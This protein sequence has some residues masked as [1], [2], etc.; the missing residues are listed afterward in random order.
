MSANFH[1]QHLSPDLMLDALA[2]VHIYPESGLL[3][4][5]SY[6]NRVVQFK[7]D[8][9][10]RYVA[11]FYRP[12]RWNQ[13]QLEEEH[14]F[15]R[16][17]QQEELPIA[18]PIAFDGQS[19]LAFAGF[20]YCV[21]PSTGGRAI[22]AENWDQLE[23]LGSLLGQIHQVGLR[24]PFSARP[25]L[26]LTE[27]IQAGLRQLSQSPQVPARWQI[28]WMDFAS[29]CQRQLASLS[30]KFRRV[31]GDCHLGNVL[32]N[33]GL[34]L[35]DFDDCLQAPAVQD[36]W[37]LLHGDRAEQQLQLA[38]LLDGY[39][40]F[41]DFSQSELAWIEPLRLRRM[42]QQMAWIDKRWQDPLFVSS[43]PW[44][45]QEDY[46]QGQWRSLQQ[47]LADCQ[48]PPFSVYPAY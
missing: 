43:F 11:K 18:Y 35:L 21:Y 2:A 15:L 44:F 45:G 7:A 9:G 33:D 39:Q 8:D 48:Q 27:D 28:K 19:L 13:Q 4:L 34:T 26:Q 40:N 16:E 10:R 22:D 29:D 12:E 23:Q 30:G 1:F 37:L 46:W 42:V 20:Y 36:L 38:T 6:E 32:A 47:Q 17:L 3:P 25:S 14:Q 24:R 5:N 41:C 31:H